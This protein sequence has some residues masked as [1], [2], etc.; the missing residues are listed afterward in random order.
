MKYEYWQADNGLWYWHLKAP[1]GESIAFSEG[2]PSKLNCHNA[3]R[4]VKHTAHAPEV[5]LTPAASGEHVHH[6]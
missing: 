4:L 6:H 3:I 1:N 5:N 2:Y